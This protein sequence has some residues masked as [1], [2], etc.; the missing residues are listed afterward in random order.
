[1]KSTFDFPESHVTL[2]HPLLREFGAMI[3]KAIREAVV[4]WLY[5]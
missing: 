4:Q 1:M 3:E 5:F 2:G